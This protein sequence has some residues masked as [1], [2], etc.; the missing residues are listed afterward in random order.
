MIRQKKKKKKKNRKTMPAKGRSLF[1]LY[2]FI[3]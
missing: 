3:E 2:I 1:S